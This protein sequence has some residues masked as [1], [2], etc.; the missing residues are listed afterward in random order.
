M[1]E[2]LSPL[3]E[4]YKQ[5]QSY[6]D[7]LIEFYKKDENQIIKCNECVNWFQMYGSWI[8]GTCL[9]MKNSGSP[10]YDGE[11]PRWFIFPEYEYCNH[12]KKL[13]KDQLPPQM[14]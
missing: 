11:E 14:P 12:F 6:H 4:T 2:Q 7:A 8:E 13:P 1:K 9:K 3:E 10:V 5:R